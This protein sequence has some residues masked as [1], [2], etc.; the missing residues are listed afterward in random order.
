MRTTKAQ[1]EARI[2]EL[3]STLTQCR[4]IAKRLLRTVP[5]RAAFLC[6]DLAHTVGDTVDVLERRR[7]KP[8]VI[9]KPKDPLPHLAA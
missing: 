1:L 2:A 5:H 3:E 4:T 8:H 7:D 6:V 9:H